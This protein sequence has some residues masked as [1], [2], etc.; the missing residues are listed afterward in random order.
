MLITG[1]G[2]YQSKWVCQWVELTAD[3][4]CRGILLAKRGDISS[5]IDNITRVSELLL[6]L[7]ILLYNVH[8]IFQAIWKDDKNPKLIF[9]RAEL[10]EKVLTDLISLFIYLFIIFIYLLYFREVRQKRP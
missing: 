8:S 9:L 1:L 2:F 4:L 10:R 7:L 3:G 6:V 5:A